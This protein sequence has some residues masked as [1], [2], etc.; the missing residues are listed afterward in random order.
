MERMLEA[1]GMSLKVS[2]SVNE[3]DV[4]VEYPS[5]SLTLG[6]RIKEI[7]TMT[8]YYLKGL[9]EGISLGAKAVKEEHK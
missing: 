4:G 3:M 8:E 5:A 6:T 9:H 1:M 7:E 2:R